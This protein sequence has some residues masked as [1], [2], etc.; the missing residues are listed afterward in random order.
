MNCE[1]RATLPLPR[2]GQR[3]ATWPYL[4]WTRK[5]SAKNT[6]KLL[7][8]EQAD[9]YRPWLQNDK[10]L[11]ILVRE[12][13]ALAIRAAQAAEGWGRNDAREVRNE[14]RYLRVGR[15]IAEQVA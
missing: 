12:L 15:E 5:V 13:E 11:H 4:Y 3:P 8:P 1:S 6:S 14:R 2:P 7:T 9:R 10:R